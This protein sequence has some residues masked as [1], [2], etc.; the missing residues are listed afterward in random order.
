MIDFSLTEE[1]RIIRTELRK[2]CASEV[3]P[4]ALAVDRDPDHDFDWEIIK[5]LAEH[6][7]LGLIVPEAYGGSGASLF[8]L[9]VAIE[10]LAYADAGIATTVGVTWGLQIMI[11]LEGNPAHME[12]YLPLLCSKDGNL[13][14][15]ASTEPGGGSDQLSACRFRP[16]Y[17]QTTAVLVGDEYVI[18]GT[19]QFTSNG[20]LAKLYLVFATRDRKAGKEATLQIYVPG[21]APGLSIGRTEDKMGQR[22]GQTTSLIFEDVRV[23]IENLYGEVGL[24]IE[25]NEGRLMPLSRGAIGLIAVGIARA[26]YDEALKYAKQRVQGG[27]PIIEHQAVAMMLADM[28]MN[29]EAGRRLGHYALWKNIQTTGG[30]SDLASMAKVFCSD[31][32]MKVT[33]DAVQVLGGYGYMKEY[34]VEKLMRDAKLTQIYEGANQICRLDVM[35]WK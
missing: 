13:G 10:E 14:G 33:T 11:M 20:G 25:Y 34:L 22:A 3:R 2:F 1:E 31:M 29:I 12:Q 5:R 17:T 26:A 4:R 9:G 27:K 21:D 8:S 15:M 28:A 19:K 18:N 30:A 24:G 7:Y 16:G 32:A 35:G 23:P 6:G